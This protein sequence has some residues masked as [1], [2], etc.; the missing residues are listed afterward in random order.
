VL[1]GSWVPLSNRQLQELLL[2]RG[3]FGRGA[4]GERRVLC[5]VCQ[6]HTAQRDKLG[7]EQE[8]VWSW[9][10]TWNLTGIGT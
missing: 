7:G 9:I 4:A 8:R 6:A 5:S 1:V 10:G 3:L 2:E